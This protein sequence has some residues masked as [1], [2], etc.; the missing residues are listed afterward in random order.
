VKDREKGSELLT[1]I[2]IIKEFPD[3]FTKVL[4]GLRPEREVKVSIDIILGLTP[5]A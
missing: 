1:Y 4:P 5:I 3:V 2:P